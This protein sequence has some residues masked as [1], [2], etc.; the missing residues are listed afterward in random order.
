ME[1]KEASGEGYMNISTTG[2][3][4]DY[5]Q[6][7]DFGFDATSIQIDAIGSGYVEIAWTSG[8]YATQED[9]VCRIDTGKSFT[10]ENIRHSKLVL[11]TQY[12][13]DDARIIAY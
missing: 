3:S 8:T 10:Y 13:N 1:R 7:L 4:K 12:D 6:E 5:Y 2:L 9:A 11:R